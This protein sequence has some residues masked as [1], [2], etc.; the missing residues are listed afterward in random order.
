LLHPGQSILN[1]MRPK[2]RWF[3]VIVDDMPLTDFL[4]LLSISK[5][6]IKLLSL[7]LKWQ[8]WRQMLRPQASCL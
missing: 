6:A 3:P 1:M 8:S 2:E 7:K 5:H 4:S